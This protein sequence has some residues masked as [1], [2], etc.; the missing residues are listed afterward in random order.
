VG[1]TVIIVICPTTIIIVICPTT[2]STDGSHRSGSIL[3]CGSKSVIQI[4]SCPATWTHKGH[5][6]FRVT[7]IQCKVIKSNAPCFANADFFYNLVPNAWETVCVST[8]AITSGCHQDGLHAIRFYRTESCEIWRAIG[9]SWL[10]QFQLQGVCRGWAITFASAD[11]G[12]DHTF[13]ATAVPAGS[14]SG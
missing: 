13:C 12:G 11:P 2:V 1:N 10:T 3:E 4:F 7:S 5:A 8:N 14:R 9:A 6:D